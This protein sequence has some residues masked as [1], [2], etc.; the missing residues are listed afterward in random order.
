LDITKRIEIDKDFDLCMC[1]EVGEHVEESSARTLVANLTNLSKRIAFSAAIPMQGGNHHVN[2]QWPEY[3]AE[4]FAEH[5]YFLEWDPRLLIWD[6]SNVAPCYRQ[7][8]LIYSHAESGKIVIPPPLVH[9]EAWIQALKNRR[10]PLW[11]SAI[12]LLPRPLLR[13]CKKW[14]IFLLGGHTK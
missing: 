10:T 1:L 2:E 9:P 14:L 6:N 7:N 11:R 8:L 12:Y 13:G 5:N 3:W 4:L